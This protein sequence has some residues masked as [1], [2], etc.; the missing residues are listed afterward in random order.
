MKIALIIGITGQDGSYPAEFLLKKGYEI[1]R[2]KRRVSSFNTDRID[3]LYKD[4]HDQDVKK[5]L[6][7]GDMTEATNLIR[8]M[9]EIKPAEIYN[10]AAQ[11]QVQTQRIKLVIFVGGSC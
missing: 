10:L 11:A 6:H 2:I 7:Y 9:Q 4:P 1:H 5:N 8:I 3:H